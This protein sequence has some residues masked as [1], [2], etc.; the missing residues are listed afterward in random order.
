MIA[1]N[2][3]LWI[4][5]ACFVAEFIGYFLHKLLHSHRIEFLSRGHMVHHLR[6]YGPKMPK[7]TPKYITSVDGRAALLNYGME[8]IVPITVIYSTF[9]LIFWIADVPWLYRL[10]FITVSSVWALT[11][12]G[13]M[14]D[15][16]HISDFWM[17]KNRFLKKWSLHV[18]K[19]HDIHHLNLADNG[20]MTKN[21]GICFFWMDRLFGTLCQKH[22]HFNEKGFQEAQR[23]YSY[24]DK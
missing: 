18:R 23:V 19:L 8:W 22:Q 12:F 10:V 15:A 13:Y 21:F 4:V 17:T 3:L 24:I 2:I 7:R 20:K 9:F 14:H 1:L 16:S 5:G 11:M 6:T